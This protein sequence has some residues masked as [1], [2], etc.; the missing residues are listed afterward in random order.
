MVSWFLQQSREK[1]FRIL[2][3]VILLVSVAFSLEFSF[4]EYGF[5]K[6]LR[7]LLILWGLTAAAWT[8]FREKRIP[9][10]ILLILLL[11]RS[12]ILLIE[13]LCYP[14]YWISFAISSI[15]GFAIG[16]GMFLLC[17]LISKGG[18]GAGDVK[19][20]AVLGY[21]LGMSGIFTCSFLSIV[22][23]A[24][25]SILLLILRKVKLKEE[26]AFAPFVLTGA[27]LTIGLGV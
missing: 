9:N 3:A 23:A 14:D 22:C 21:Y 13:I 16:G 10:R 27:I 25:Y 18:M 8:D 11:L 7:L 12:V 15:G 1:N 5:L 6:S 2:L 20:M 19:L 4:F 17:Y 26:I 24:I